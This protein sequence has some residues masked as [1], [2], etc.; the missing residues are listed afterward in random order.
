MI[1]NPVN[2]DKTIASNGKS[3]RS[4]DGLLTLS[5]A[6]IVGKMKKE[7][8]IICGRRLGG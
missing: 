5:V 6:K 1:D 3:R 4:G 7:I 2:N 8:V